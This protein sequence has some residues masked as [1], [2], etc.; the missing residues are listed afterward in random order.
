MGNFEQDN[1][2]DAPC[3]Q[4]LSKECEYCNGEGEYYVSCCGDEIDADTAICP[5]CGE[6]SGG[7]PETCEYCN[8]TG[9]EGGEL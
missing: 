4:P 2:L 1:Q 5:S 7:E 9:F 3:N 6:P 8:G